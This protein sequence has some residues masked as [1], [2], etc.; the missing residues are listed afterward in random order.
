MILEYSETRAVALAGRQLQLVNG[1]G[2]EEVALATCSPLID[3]TRIQCC[4]PFITAG[5]KGFG[6]THARLLS[7]GGEANAL[8]ARCGLSEVLVNYALIEPDRFKD[9]RAPVGRHRGDAHLGHGLNHTIE[10]GL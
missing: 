4:V 6:V 5:S 10:V 2:A 8:N 3:A 7:D 9:L 1:D